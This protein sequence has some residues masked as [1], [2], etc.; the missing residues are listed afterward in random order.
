MGEPAIDERTTVATQQVAAHIAGFTLLL[1]MASG[2]VG[3][4]AFGRDPIVEGNA[5]ATAQNVLAHERGVRGSLACEIVMLN[6]DV[7]LA[8][9]LYALLRPVN[10]ALALLGSFW[11]IAN[12]VLLGVG[13]AASLVS[14]DL[15]G[16]PNFNSLMNAGQS[17]AMALVFFDLHNRL[18]LMGLMFFCLGAGVHSWLLYK[19]RYIP[20]IISGLYLF[21]SI[22]ML[23][24]CFV[25]VTFPKTRAV[26]DPAFLVPDFFAEL[27]AALWLAIKG[28]RLPA[29]AETISVSVLT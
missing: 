17:H 8:L 15:L 5:V 26:L 2:F 20:R 16:N 9:A 11:R 27:S 24:C 22:E 23:L 3:M 12:A 19:S 1:L 25:F 28:A 10:A 13:V 14:L 6:C 4:F 29:P 7:V 21:A 18:S